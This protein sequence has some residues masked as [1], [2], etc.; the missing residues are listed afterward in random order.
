MCYKVFLFPGSH[1]FNRL[2]KPIKFADY[3]GF[4]QIISS[5]FINYFIDLQTII[6]T[7]NELLIHE[8]MSFS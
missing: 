1:N 8:S 5:L 2:C 7:F 4:N 6:L 3:Q